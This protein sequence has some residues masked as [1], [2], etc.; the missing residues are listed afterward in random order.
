MDFYELQ[1]PLLKEAELFTPHDPNVIQKQIATR[2]IN[3]D[4]T[5]LKLIIIS[6]PKEIPPEFRNLVLETATIPDVIDITKNLNAELVLYDNTSKYMYK[7]GTDIAVEISENKTRNALKPL[8]Q[9]SKKF[10][11]ERGFSE[12]EIQTMLKEEN[13]DESDLIPLVLVISED[14]Y[15]QSLTAHRYSVTNNFLAVSCFAGGIS[16]KVALDCA[17]KAIGA[18]I[19]YALSSSGTKIWSKYSIKKAF[20]VVAKR[21]LGPIGVAIAVV[22]F[23]VCLAD[24]G[25]ANNAYNNV[26]L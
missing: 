6:S 23:S 7:E 4:S 17:I 18:D 21:C 14:E 15:N 9:E 5:D 11:Y 12:E 25:L 19:L 10:L 16:M 26:H 3:L 22:E 2:G 13:A 8:L 1:L 20:K 24:A